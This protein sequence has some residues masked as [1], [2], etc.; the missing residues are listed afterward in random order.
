[1]A[2]TDT[3]RFYAENAEAYARHRTRPTRQQLDAFLAQVEPGARILELGCGN[4]MD[5]HYML[6]RG[7]DVDAT[8]GTPELV[9]AAR[10]RIGD[11]ARVMRFDDLDAENAYDGVWAA[12]SLLHAPA[13]DLPTILASIR[14]AVRSSG[15]FVASFKSGEGE[16]RDSMGR[17]FNYPSARSLEA[18]YRAAGWTD[19]G[20][21]KSMAGGYDGLATEWLWM[22]AR[23]P[24]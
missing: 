7:F 14:R 21:E 4:G 19:L 8:D 22:T 3:M 13:S 16:G 23:C 5:A 17:Y 20:L 6:E 15:V 11:R 10:Q 18:T 1:M 24:S 12:A 2:D 9:Q